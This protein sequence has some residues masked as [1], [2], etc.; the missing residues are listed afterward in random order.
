MSSLL[1]NENPLQVLP[2]LACAVGLN[3]AL[4]A[5]QM[6]YWM[7][8]SRHFYDG[9]RW[10]YNS[11]ASWQ[12]QFPFW[13]EATIKRALGS[14]ENQ[15]VIVSGNYN[16]DPRDRSKWYSLNYEVLRA[17]EN[18]TQPVDDAFGQN[19][20]MEQCKMTKCIVAD[21][22]NAPGQNDPMQ[23]VNMTQPL[24]ETTTEITQETTTEIKNT[25]GTSA[26]AAMPTRT[27]KQNYSPEFEAAWQAY[28][29]RAGGNSKSA[30]WKY[31]KA[32]LKD[33]VKPEDMLAGVKRYAAYCQ[34]TG[35]TGTQF[36]KQAATFFGP[37]R[38]FEESWQA[39]S[40]PG[41]GRR[42]AFPISGFSEQ[43]YGKT[44]CNW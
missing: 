19:D 28:P 3:E 36:V 31:W 42:S 10:I 43:D 32:R 11:V 13:S 37:D 24:P 35:N 9:R 15:G 12:K 26:D 44:D 41:G 14:L 5:Q 25:S 29:K 2:S 7:G 33:G 30:A 18:T 20:Q 40:A 4:I 38:H 34:L 23:L 22:T 27:A 16:P 17:I 21:C 8:K 39:P 6:H 1:I